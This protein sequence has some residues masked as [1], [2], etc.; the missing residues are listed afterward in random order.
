MNSP[1]KT[2]L[3]RERLQRELAE[4]ETR[5]VSDLEQ[6]KHKAVDSLKPSAWIARHPV[7]AI[8]LTMAAGAAAA[9]VA[10]RFRRS[11]SP[12]TGPAPGGTVAEGNWTAIPGTPSGRRGSGGGDAGI[13]SLAWNELRRVLM[14]KGI[15][16]AGAFI[17]ERLHAYAA[18]S[19]SA[20]D[21]DG[22]DRRGNGERGGSGAG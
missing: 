2:R 17:E 11:R 14:R 20:G 6:A 4:L 18:R 8:A 5:I 9:L 10:G 3:R 16:A 1:R 21:G 7:R 15:Q 12:S 22:G 19:A 13:A